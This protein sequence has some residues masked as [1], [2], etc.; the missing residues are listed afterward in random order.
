[1]TDRELIYL[2]TEEVKKMRKENLELTKQLNEFTE[3]KERTKGGRKP[4][5]QPETREV[6]R[7]RY[8]TEYITYQELAE[9]YGVTK[10]AICRIIK[11]NK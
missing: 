9:E 7:R 3:W 1:M 5:I 11:E 8:K 10:S 6:I 2:L 4:K